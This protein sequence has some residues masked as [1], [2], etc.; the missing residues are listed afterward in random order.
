MNLSAFMLENAVTVQNVQ[1][2]ASSRFVDQASGQP[3]LWEIRCLTS[4]EDEALRASCMEQSPLP[5]KRGQFTRELNVNK[6]LG[7]LAAACTV[8][9]NLDDQALQ[10]SYHVMGADALLKA[11][12]TAGEYAS[13]LVKVQAI[14]GFDQSLQDEADT[15]KN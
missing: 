10:D 14:C 1:Y 11:M 15:V 5:G 2:A 7:K 3:A 4:A 12:L 13:Y 8:H 6:Y 9:P